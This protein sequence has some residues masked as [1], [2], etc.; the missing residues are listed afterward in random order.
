M[1]TCELKQILSAIKQ[2]CWESLN[3][4]NY[5]LLGQQSIALAIAMKDY[6]DALEAELITAYKKVA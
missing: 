1:G 5:E 3:Q 2:E 6:I 4:N